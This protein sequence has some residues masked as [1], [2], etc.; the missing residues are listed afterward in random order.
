MA[1]SPLMRSLF[2]RDR[3]SP[4]W[5]GSRSA[6]LLVAIAT[7]ALTELRVASAQTNTCDR[8]KG[9]LTVVEGAVEVQRGGTGAWHTAE[10]GAPI[11]L[12]DAIRVQRSA[13]ALLTLPDDS[14]LR[15]DENTTVMLDA[16]EPAG[17][18]LI[19][20][21]RGLIHV[22][23]RDPRQLRF[24]TPFTNAGLEGTEFDI[25]VNER[26]RQTE[27]AVLEGAVRVTSPAG[28]IQV[29]S[30]HLAVAKAGEVPFATSLA[31]PIELMRWAS[32]YPS[33]LDGALPDPA[34]EPLRADDAEFFARRAAAHLATARLPAA[35]ADLATAWRWRR[36][37]RRR[38]RSQA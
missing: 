14:T 20:L 17:G 37:S 7:M 4:V 23:S 27:I 15:L 8:W 11:C 31:S 5:R 2:A 28:E 32:H 30:G 16:P 24:T 1:E 10:S 34:Q 9:E 13:R 6:A 22:I 35:Q 29:G 19:N 18:S 33:I 26:D 3:P 38:S 12:G 36:A 21:V 25:G